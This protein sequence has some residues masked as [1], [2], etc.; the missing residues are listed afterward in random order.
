MPPPDLLTAALVETIQRGD[1]IL[2][3]GAGASHGAVGPKGEKAPSGDEL[4]NIL[5]DRFLGGAL[6][7][8]S[9]SQVAELAK[10]EA[11]L[12]KVQAAIHELFNPLQPEKFHLLIP[13]F[14]WF[15]IVGTNYDLVV[16]RA[17][18]QCAGREQTLAPIVRDGDNFSERL[19]D[20]ASVVYLKLHGCITHINDENLP[21]ILA[22]E[23]Y[24]KHRKNRERLFK[25][26]QDWGRERPI[27]FC[28]YDIADPNIQQI[29]FDLFDL[30]I[31]RPMYAIVSPDIDPIVARYW[32]SKR[33][34]VCTMTFEQFLL[35][36]NSAIPQPARGLATLIKNKSTSVAPWIKTKVGPS[37]LLLA[38][39][40][41]ELIHVHKGMPTTGVAP[42][43][44]YRG[45]S[46]EWGAIQQELDVYRRVADDIILEAFL[47]YDKAKAL[48][49]FLL[50]GHAG[51]GKSVV[52]RRV[53]W[54]VAHQFDMLVFYLMEGGLLRRERLLEL[55]ELT[56]ERIA[57]VVEDAIPHIR[58]ISDLI[59]WA[60]R[61]NVPLTLI[62]AARTNEWNVYAGDLEERVANDYELRDLS[63]REISQLLDKLNA[64]KCLGRLAKATREEQLEHFQLTSGRQ[65][66]VAL[67]DISSEKPFEEIVFDEYQNVRPLEARLLYLDI[68]TLH[69]LGVG[70]RAG[71]I[72]RISGITFENFRREF[73]RP[74]EHVVHTYFDAATRDNM[75]RSRHPV[76]AEI[77]FKQAVPNPV[78]RAQQIVRIIGQLDVDYGCDRTAFNEVV[79]GRVLADLFADKKLAYQIFN[80]A[81]ESGAPLSVIEHQRAV[82]E[83]HHRQANLRAAM[84]AIDRAEASLEYPD[85]AVLHTK[86]SI[87][88]H[89]ALESP[90]RLARETLRGTA[91]AIVAKQ[92]HNSRVSHSHHLAGQILLDE[93]KDKLEDIS[94]D[95]QS[96]SKELTERGIAELIR[97]CEEI[98]S[99]GLQKFPGDQ[100]LLTLEADLAKTVD[101]ES[102]AVEALTRAF[103]S[104]PGRSYV[105]VRLARRE[106]RQGD[107]GHAKEI[108]RRSLSANPSS[109]EVHLS[110]ARILMQEDE[111][112]NSEE[113]SYHL[114]RSFTSG[115]SNL[116]AQFWYARHNYLFGDREAAAATFKQLSNT[117]TPLEY[118]KK[119]KDVVCD[120][121]GATKKFSGSVVKAG[122]SYCFVRCPDLRADIFGHMSEFPEQEWQKVGIG[123]QLEFEIG[124]SL[125]GPQVVAAHLT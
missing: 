67:H 23:E 107:P 100:F 77:V 10:N 2:F 60:V 24:A 37:S 52:L 118:K 28:G 62:L 105:A 119:V 91:K 117:W 68:C 53:A 63:E 69:R 90:Q 25:H 103:E 66:L 22:S 70:I 85:R 39:L 92:M 99:E 8:K 112:S 49:V 104:S 122:E 13:T 34:A 56:G 9:L 48:Q 95:R 54:D 27:I 35:Q 93:L 82:F 101:D 121:D 123:S 32:S 115:D 40:Q 125:R 78:D 108:L 124:F 19:R 102:R 51:S 3:L 18:D 83:M 87:L 5:S 86:A 45:H 17:Y 7:S 114:K 120:K 1:A 12:P 21:L 111:A 38:Y 72:S 41:D 42:S 46:T 36:L 16:E 20:L 58:D 80:A 84:N 15:A 47:E 43:D 55:H 4:R 64:H 6:K 29:L 110:L 97:Q 65:L 106:L 61:N 96:S 81:E 79:R 59:S 73:F 88:R 75:Y 113:V 30:G 71:L 11:G 74:L 33:F 44:F 50:K 98:V 14:R 57:V 109:K 31:N 89:L 94:G 26:L 116:D 76:I